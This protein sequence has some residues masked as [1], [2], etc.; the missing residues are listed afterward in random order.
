VRR[1]V[2]AAADASGRP[3]PT[4][5]DKQNNG[6]RNPLNIGLSRIIRPPIGPIH[7]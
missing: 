4:E 6:M 1:G 5:S 7:P 2:D 3:T